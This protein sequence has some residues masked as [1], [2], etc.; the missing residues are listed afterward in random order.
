M[1]QPPPWKRPGILVG[2]PVGDLTASER[3]LLLSAISV[4]AGRDPDQLDA[5][6]TLVTRAGPPR[7]TRIPFH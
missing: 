1:K 2:R 7:A 6:L 4:L 5:Q 3:A